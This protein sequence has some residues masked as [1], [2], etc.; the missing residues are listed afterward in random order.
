MSIPTPDEINAMTDLELKAEENRLRRAA[1]RQNLKLE[2][3][4]VRDPRAIDFGTY[5]LV[6]TETNT[7]V[8]YGTGDYGLGLDDVARQLFDDMTVR[9][10]DGDDHAV[11]EWLDN[12]NPDRDPWIEY[13]RRNTTGAR[14][15]G[16]LIDDGWVLHYDEDGSIDSWVLGEWDSSESAVKA[17][18]DFLRRWVAD[19]EAVSSVEG[20]QR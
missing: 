12:H 19:D 3:A 8:A 9:I 5:R 10:Y 2:K 15:K 20:D 11:V 6:S 17:A 18:R 13:H 1:E 7:V 14:F 4:R 16:K